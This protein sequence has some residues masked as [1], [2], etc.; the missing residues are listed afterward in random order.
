MIRMGY[1]RSCRI[2]INLVREVVTNQNI[3]RKLYSSAHAQKGESRR[4]ECLAARLSIVLTIRTFA[5]KNDIR[6]KEHAAY[7]QHQ[8][9]VIVMLFGA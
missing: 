6:A 4:A 9:P 7:V 5:S 3:S 2:S 1:N 8:A